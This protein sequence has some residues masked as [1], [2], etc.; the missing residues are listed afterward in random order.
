MADPAQIYAD[1]RSKY[2]SASEAVQ[3]IAL[4]IIDAGQKLRSQ[5]R[6]QVSNAAGGGYPGV[7]TVVATIDA[8]TWPTAQAIHE[9]LVAKHEAHAAMMSAYMAMPESVQKLLPKPEP[10]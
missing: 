6:V 5:S 1:A 2:E 10:M 3:R 7:P 4:V 8:N 9:A